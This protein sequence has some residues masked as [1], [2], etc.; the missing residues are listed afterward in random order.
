MDCRI[1]EEEAFGI[2]KVRAWDSGE[3]DIREIS[4]QRLVCTFKGE[5]LAGDFELRRM[6]WYP[7]NRWILTK[8]G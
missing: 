8:T 3:V 6:L 7:G 5:K 4:P 2:G 1:F